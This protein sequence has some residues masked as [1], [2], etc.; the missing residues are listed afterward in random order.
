MKLLF[1]IALT[2]CFSAAHSQFNDLYIGKAEFK[3]ESEKQDYKKAVE[4]LEK[5]VKKEP[6]NAEAHYFLGY[7]YDRLNAR[8]GTDIIKMD[9]SLTMKASQEFETVNKIS[10]VYKGESLILDPYS[11]ITA[12][13]GSQ[14]MAY[15]YKDKID[16]AKWA[17]NEG[18]KRD[19]FSELYL[20][21]NRTILKTCTDSAY[22]V[23]SGDNFTFPFWYLQIIEGYRPD[24]SVIDI[25]LLNTIWYP[26]YLLREKKAELSVTGVTLDS[27]KYREWKDSSITVAMP[28]FP[29]KFSWT[30]KANNQDAYM[31]RGGQVFLDMVITNQFKHD[32]F[33]TTSFLISDQLGLNNYL[34]HYFLMDK[35]SVIKNR[36]WTDSVMAGI[37]NFDFTKLDPKRINKSAQEV[38]S[39]NTLRYEYCFVIQEL[40][41]KSRN[42]EAK[43][44][45]D[46]LLLNLPEKQY[47]NT[48]EDIKNF[49]R[50]I[51]F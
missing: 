13:W 41:S 1:S 43:K 9:L 26:Q 15:L 27:L 3:K 16:S 19:G 42:K 29:Y 40:L 8:D 47:P 18:K 20:A 28:N 48:K 11:K 21:I 37:H 2:F 17:F 25:S 36:Y 10:P 51:R 35:V 24:V 12:I 6:N 33:F 38:I 30:A 44:V 31:L 23:S 49:L 34:D 39:I 32:V 4:F 46:E 45:Y 14:A 22:L 7:A 5:A 50:K